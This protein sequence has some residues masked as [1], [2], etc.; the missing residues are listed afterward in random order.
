[1]HA[2]F[3]TLVVV[4]TLLGL[5]FASPA[6]AQGKHNDQAAKIADRPADRGRQLEAL[7]DALA[8]KNKPPKI[9]DRQGRHRP[10]FDETYDWAEQ[11]RVRKAC[12][13][14]N[15]REAADGNELWQH[16]AEHADDQR[17]AVTC[18]V[19]TDDEYV[20]NITVGEICRY[21]AYHDLVQP[22]AGIWQGKSPFMGSVTGDPRYTASTPPW[23]NLKAW[24]GGR[25]GKLLWELQVEVGQWGIKTLNDVDGKRE[26]WKA[27]CLQQ[28][29]AQ[30]EALRR[31]K[32][33]IVRQAPAD[34]DGYK[35]AIICY[36]G[37]FRPAKGPE[38]PGTPYV[39]ETAEH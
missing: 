23:H 8:N 1:M 32:K 12:L 14:L 11:E 28:T 30:I 16:V 5:A 29:N 7:I 38:V 13:A 24:S 36:A 35:Y 21:V 20:L 33:P 9:V 17:Y 22:F 37:V 26:K 4:F 2:R 18:L 19:R 6:R 15:E 27:D 10:L 31:T 34:F 39:E 3:P 25:K